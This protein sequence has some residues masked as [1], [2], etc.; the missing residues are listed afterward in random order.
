MLVDGWD[1]DVAEGGGAAGSC[2][3]GWKCRSDDPIS[4][5]SGPV[6]PISNPAGRHVNDLGDTTQMLD[7]ADADGGDEW[8][9]CEEGRVGEK[10]PAAGRSVARL[11]EQSGGDEYI[12]ELDRSTL[13]RPGDSHQ[14]VS[15]DL[16]GGCS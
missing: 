14:H 2:P 10:T 3:H 9:G 5:S 4:N 7:V 11:S 6:G 1:W 15:S 8:G 12:E 13:Q 16:P